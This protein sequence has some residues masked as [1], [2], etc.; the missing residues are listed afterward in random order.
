MGGGDFY[1]ETVLPLPFWVGI[2]IIVCVAFLTIKLVADKRSSLIFLLITILLIIAFRVA[3]P[4]MFTTIPA[5]EPDSVHYLNVVNS[6]V[7]SGVDFANAGNYEHDYPLAFL[8]AFIVIK[9]GVPIDTFFRAVP[10]MIYAIDLILIFFIIS[11]ITPFKENRKIG[12]VSVFFFSISSLGYWVS[13]HYCPDLVG[14][15]LF[16]F[17]LFLCIRFAKRGDWNLKIILPVLSSIILLI[18]SHHLTTL[19]FILT[20]LGLALSTWFFNPPQIKGKAIAFF[21]MGIFTYTFWFAY[22][23]LMYP[24]FFN[25][26]AYFSGFGSPTQLAQ[27]AGLFN[28]ITFVIYPALIIGLFAIEL[29][30]IMQFKTLSEIIKLRTKIREVRIRESE[31]IVLVFSIGFIL[32]LGL[33]FVGFAVPVAFPTRVLEVLLVGLYPLSAITFLKVQETNNPK[34]KWFLI[35][36]LII[37]LI[38]VLTGLH[39]YYTQIQRRVIV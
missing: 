19:Y 12:A 16:L 22:G 29:L 15:M 39:R 34:R 32:I 25:V 21:V 33:F 14:S 5:Y 4:I 9:L 27:Q 28:N 35:I 11:E 26:Y 8:I 31:N 1:V 38:V 13:V 17:S 10:F 36:L 18:L 3:F 30:R 2:S 6:W 24:E 23:S 7:K 37:I 20:L